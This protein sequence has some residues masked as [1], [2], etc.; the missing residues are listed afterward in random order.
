MGREWLV[1]LVW[2]L[3]TTDHEGGGQSGPGSSSGPEVYKAVEKC[4]DHP[5][6]LLLCSL[7]SLAALPVGYSS[8]FDIEPSLFPTSSY[9]YV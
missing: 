9:A 5:G 7:L 2:G 6:P 1:G 8:C 4:K 3:G